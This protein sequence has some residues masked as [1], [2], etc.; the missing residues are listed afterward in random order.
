MFIATLFV[1]ASNWNPD[2]CLVMYEWLNKVCY[3]QTME[4]DSA[5]KRNVLLLY[6]NTWMNLEEIMI[7]KKSIS[8]GY[9]L[10]GSIYNICGIT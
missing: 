4:Y 7:S 5:I 9:I 10:L 1:I 2:V 3:V 8:K 6:A